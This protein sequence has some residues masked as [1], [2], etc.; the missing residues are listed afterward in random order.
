MEGLGF[1]LD[2]TT[3]FILAGV[4]FLLSIQ[5]LYHSVIKR[6]IDRAW[7]LFCQFQNYE[8]P[9]KKVRE[10]KYLRRY[11]KY[12][13]ISEII[14]LPFAIAGVFLSPLFILALGVDVVILLLT[15]R[16]W[17]KVNLDPTC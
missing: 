12:L 14:L 13:L 3:S 15:L 11:T 7:K 4:V 17:I 5:K 9:P 1:V 10:R 6:S 8:N 16:C 2:G